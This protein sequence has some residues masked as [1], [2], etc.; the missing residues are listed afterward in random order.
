M[1]EDNRP[2]GRERNITGQ[3]SGVYRRGSGTGGGPVGG[4]GGYSGR[5]GTP[6]GG[7]GNGGG[8]G[9]TR[10][11]GGSGKI[12]GIIIAVIVVLAG[13]GGLSG[14]LSNLSGGGTTDPVNT[15]NTAEL[16]SFLSSFTGSNVS[17]G[18]SGNSNNTTTP[19]N[20]NVA[21]GVRDRYTAIAGDGTDT[22]TLMM[23][24]CGTDL[25]S[26]HGM[27]SAD[28]KEMA[29]A[30]LSDK[31]NVIVMT[32]GCTAWKT[33]GISNSTTQIYKIENGRLT[34]LVSDNGKKSMTDPGTLTEFIKYCKNNYPANRYELVLWD[35]G[36]GT[37]GG[38]GY[39]QLN[40]SK[41]AM[42]IGGINT[43]LNNAG[44]KFDF[45]GFDACL[46]ATTEN[47]LML[48]KHA[49]YLIASEETEPGIGWYYTRWLTELSKDTSTPTLQ[50]GQMIIDDY[51]EVCG[52]RC[53]GQ[54]TTLSL[55]DLAELEYTVPQSLRDF[56]SKTTQMIKSNGYKTVSNARSSSREFAVSSKRD[57]VDLVHLAKNMNTSEGGA[58]AEKILSAVKYNRTS[59]E[60]TNSYGLSI[61]FPYNNP[62]K[63]DSA[64]AT[65]DQ[66][67]MDGEYAE[68]IK[69]F[70]GYETA[71]QTASGTTASPLS[72]LLGN[73]NPS[74]T[75][76]EDIISSLLGSLLGS[77]SARDSR[78]L[79]ALDRN[80]ASSYIAKNQFDASKLR[81]K[82]NG[83]GKVMELSLD[84]WKLVSDLELNVFIDDGEGFIDLG[85]DNTFEFS[86]NGE[87]MSADDMTWLAVDGQIVAYYHTDTYDDGTNYRIC[88]RIP[89]LLNGDR[90]DLIVVFDNADPHGY[91]A[92]A[93]YDY[94][95]GE[96]DA[97]AKETT[98]LQDGDKIDFLCDYYGYDGSFKDS[99]ILG[100]QYV[101]NGEPKIS[102]VYLPT[103][104]KYSAVYRFTDIYG[105]H[106][107][108]EEM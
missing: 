85:L 59:S 45:V 6:Q 33:S 105:Q 82:Q 70:A 32:G 93:R 10:S 16:T 3:G 50:I 52:K 90:A 81:W 43:A 13:G 19:L 41:G 51:T 100:E 42:S 65:Y 91:I 27:A 66:I 7:G 20:T 103:G 36:G 80:A 108:T 46:M 67:G 40:T 71:G 34:Q 57:L 11:S 25:E 56:A 30:E 26:K 78:Y 35:H 12:I 64:V 106:Y 38:F 79:Q 58:L 37:N 49:D 48:T 1:A 77:S 2:R 15:T 21:T 44:V 55:T 18:W 24:L 69:Q 84:Q 74:G 76:S 54:K 94:K 17:T 102:D 101:V 31:V 9:P 95:N 83:G 72:S 92:G 104:T 87:L 61:Y 22:V 5:P 63:V 96:T 97:E 99:Y 39:D 4:P 75:Q 89:V 88:G 29:Q 28:L 107:W 98:S 14:I 8:G 62:S 23:Y 86:K 53:S 73:F 60:M 68:C 47:A